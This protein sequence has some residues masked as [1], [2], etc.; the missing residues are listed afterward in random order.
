MPA[1]AA[2]KFANG[3]GGGINNIGIL[4]ISNTIIANSIRGGDFAGTAPSTNTN[5]LVE[6]GN[7]SGSP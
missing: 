6:D 5:N 4:N 3:S 2:S 1:F 7:I